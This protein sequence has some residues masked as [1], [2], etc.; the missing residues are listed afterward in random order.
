MDPCEELWGC[1]LVCHC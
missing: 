1:D